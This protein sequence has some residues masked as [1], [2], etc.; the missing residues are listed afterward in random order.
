MTDR[1]ASLKD[2]I[3]SKKHQLNLRD[4]ETDLAGDFSRRGLSARERMVERLETVL[5]TEQPFILPGERIVYTRTVRSLPE[6]FTAGEWA[7]IRSGH[8][9]HELGY[10]S[11][12]TPRYAHTIAGG[13]EKR[14]GEILAALPG[15]S[16]EETGFLGGLLRAIDAVEGLADRYRDEALRRGN[17]EAYD[18]LGRIPREGART[19]REALQFF[20]IL[21]FTLWAEGEYHNTVGRFD[22]YMLPYLEADLEAGRLS[23]GAAF[24]LLE[25]FFLSF[26][27]DSS[28]YPG[29]Q[30]G[31]NGQSMVLG[32][33]RADGKD[34]FNVL[35][36]MCLE[37]SRELKLID[38]K[39]NLR[40]DG[41]TPLSV[42]E[43]G[44][45]LTKEGLGFPQY[46]NDDVVIP[47][48]TALGY[49]PE[50]AADYSV[51]A[52]WEFIVPGRGMDIPNVGAMSFPAVLDA[53]MKDRLREAADFEEML[54][55]VEDGI[56]ASCA[57]ILSGV[58]RLWMIPAPF[59]SLLMDGCV[60]GK[61]DVS[62]GLR[63]NNYGIH[64]TGLATA[65]DSLLAI[66]KLVFDER[67]VAPGV[68]LEA[69]ASDFQGRGELLHRLRY[70]LPKLGDG[71]AEPVRLA[72]RLLDAF[73]SAVKGLR[74][75]RGGCVRAGTGSAMYYLW[76][77][78]RMGA[79]PDGRRAGEPFPANFSPS[80]FA[81]LPGP[82]SV[83]KAFSG[84]DL[85]KTINGGPLTMEFH[86]S[87]FR[88]GESV[89]KVA[90]LIRWFVGRGGHQLQLNAVNRDTLLDAQAHPEAHAQLIV[91]VWG[92]S[93]YF[94]RLDREYQDHILSRREYAAL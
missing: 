75:E 70:E 77:A 56:R 44:T 81:R 65:V 87:L 9:I 83:M 66:E 61:R 57:A 10:V 1:I 82:V 84:P 8:Y 79:S 80:L 31:D 88:G 47:G 40:V 69:V 45:L 3:V 18:V 53:A 25:E 94:N 64:G 39:I 43:M 86:D 37:A 78:A 38:P 42:Y 26:N 14:R 58:S 23:R 12:L 24:E 54:R 51:A 15:C 16:G 13:L 55:A 90:S 89:G 92:W 30:Q 33:R 6:L 50:D 7:E 2:Y 19:F 27:K 35:S 68:L 91:R 49:G 85:K 5:A 63:Y 20:R 73:A 41:G 76:H 46:A 21:H 52:C 29:V 59:L 62:L 22:Q 11:N 28:L 17:E 34:G 74:N 71:S 72:E 36:A 60:E 48:L 4:I 93:A 67:S 32:G